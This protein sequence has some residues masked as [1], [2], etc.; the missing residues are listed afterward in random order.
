MGRHLGR[1]LLFF[2]KKRRHIAQ[3]NIKVCFPELSDSEQASL[4]RKHFESVGIAF[5]EISMGWFKPYRF[6]KHR[7]EIQGAEQWPEVSSNTQPGLLM[8]GLHFSTLEIC[9]TE[10]NRR[11]RYHMMY[12]PHKNRVYDYVQMKSRERNNSVSEAIPRDD[13]RKTIKYLKQGDWVWYA[14]DQD[15]GRKLSAFVPWFNVSSATV[16]AT[17]K[18]A[19]IAEANVALLSY[20]RKADD[21]GYVIKMHP[22]IDDFPS[23]DSYSD[24]VRLNQMIEDCVRQHP[25][26]YLWVHKRFKTRPNG[27]PSIY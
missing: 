21:S 11:Y 22:I 16:T 25:E 24:L 14:P 3:C 26:Q 19:R 4:L 8:I 1:V 6:L 20:H 5:F 9:N 15:Y 7:F 17:P 10:F 27:E 2:A 18:I 23:D 13:V 12:R